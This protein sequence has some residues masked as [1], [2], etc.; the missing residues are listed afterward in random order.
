M[1]PGWR[2]EIWQALAEELGVLALPLATEDGGLDGDPV[3]T[4][5]LM[6]EF[7]EALLLEPFLE[8]VVICGGLLRATGGGTAAAELRDIASGRSRLA[9]AWAE[10]QTRF[11]FETVA[12][13]ATREGNGWRLD[14][15]KAVVTAAPWATKLLVTAR[16]EAGGLS[17]FLVDA[18]AA[19]VTLAPYPTIDGRR[20]ADI[21]LDR[22]QVGADRLLCSEGGGLPLVEAAGDAA[23]AALGA[24]AVGVMRRLLTDTMA[25]TK[26]RRQFG[27][28]IAEFQV[29]QHRMVDMFMQLEMATSAVYLATLKL[30]APRGGAR[31]RRL[32]R[33]GH[34]RESLPFH[35]PERDPAAWR[36]GHDR[37]AGDQPLL[38]ARHGDR[39]GVWHRRPP[40]RPLRQARRRGVIGAA[41]HR[42]A[43][44]Q[45][46][47]G[48]SK[49]V[50]PPPMVFAKRLGMK[51][52]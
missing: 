51:K 1:E 19:G 3:A 37:R 17:I 26:Q 14:G 49:P 29:L 21:I 40:P 32:H 6:E 2:P 36:H 25:Y 41:P 13:T 45:P 48:G 30:S 35:R 20:A 4:M 46:Y 8:T 24:E 28:P 10:P 47:A 7:G 34:G 44:G 39:S 23:I 12:T 22:V 43:A 31:P 38:Q 18:Q 33:Q 52:L 9:L 27:K 42:T 5:I 15:R 16:T 11:S 50:K